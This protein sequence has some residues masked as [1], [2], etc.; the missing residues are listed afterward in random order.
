MQL[1]DMRAV[2]ALI[3]TLKDEDGQVRITAAQALLKLDDARADEL[4]IAALH[5]EDVEVVAGAYQFFILKGENGSEA[6]LIKALNQYGT[7][8]MAEDFLNCGSILM[9]EAGRAW[10]ETNGYY[11][12]ASTGGGNNPVWGTS[13]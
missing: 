3:T 11:I 10:A 5:A 2:E 8:E 6:I 7:K 12:T 1:M 9:E 4:L 13:H